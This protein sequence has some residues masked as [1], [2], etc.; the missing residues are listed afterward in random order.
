MIETQEQYKEKN[1]S[2]SSSFKPSK[3]F[4]KYKGKGLSGLQNVGNTCFINS[5]MQVLSHTYEL[6]NFLD[7]ETYKTKLNKKCDTALLVEWNELRKLLWTQNC[8]V[9]PRRFIQITHKV[10]ELKG[11]EVF[12]GYSQNDLP[13]FLLFV[14]DC[15]H[16]SICRETPMNIV[17]VVENETDNIAQQC[18]EM[19]K[20]MYSKEYSEIWNM[21]YAVHVSEIV[22]IETHKVLT[23]NPEPF[24][25]INLP[26]PEKT[27]M[28][29]KLS[30]Y[31]CF[32]LYV[33]GETLEGD[34]AWY[35]EKTSQKESVNKRISFWSFPSILVVDL[36]RFDS[37]GK[38]NSVLVD[39]PVDNFDLS[40]YVIGYNKETYVYELYGICNHMGNQHGGHYF[41]YI[42]NA[43]GSWYMFN[44]DVVQCVISND[45]NNTNIDKI[46]TPYAYCL[47]FRKNVYKK[48]II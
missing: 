20:Q 34:N 43:D 17:G 4:H 31:D 40:K 15:F 14:I 39:V 42:K 16:N 5:C 11:V 25:M 19:I 37:M 21:F 18:Y 38:K 41:S 28:F 30:L 6:N 8:V 32:D 36:K 44:D 26:I 24:F 13:E 33:K 2:S 48:T 7:K 35:N 10:A 29:T 9:S 3:L 23:R 47:F 46:I 27:N 12:N 22:S 1:K 45:I